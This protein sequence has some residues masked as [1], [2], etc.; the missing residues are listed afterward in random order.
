MKIFIDVGGHFGETV[1]AVIDPRFGFDR[2]YSFEPVARCCREI[3]RIQDR[4]LVVVQAGLLDQTSEKYIFDPG[5]VAGSIYKDHVHVRNQDKELCKFIEAAD[6][7]E[8]NVSDLD[9]V[10]MKLNCEGS[11]CAILENLIKKNEFR[12][13]KEVLIDFDIRKIPS[14]SGRHEQILEL[15]RST[16]IRNYHFPE[17]VQY[18]FVNHFG[19]IQNWLSKTGAVEKSPPLL[20]RSFLFHTRNILLKNHI[21]YYKFKIVKLLPKRLVDTYYA[22]VKKPR[23]NH[24]KAPEPLL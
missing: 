21:G 7:F 5:S 18:G 13:I 16:N 15:L 1:E 20:L 22:K 14:Q 9:T 2:I 11:E 8:K 19:G 24:S 23:P 3:A 12:K 17:E 4:R 10:Y 6:F